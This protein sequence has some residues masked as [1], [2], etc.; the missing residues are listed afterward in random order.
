MQQYPTAAGQMLIA[1]DFF[2]GPAPEL[3]LMADRP[4]PDLDAVLRRLHERFLPN[5]VLASR[6]GDGLPQSE[7]LQGLFAGKAS[8]PP[9]PTLYVCER[10]TCQAPVTGKQAIENEIDALAGLAK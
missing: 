2:L 1:V 10:F 4:S 7:S 6:S 3:V 5:K 9:G 8:I